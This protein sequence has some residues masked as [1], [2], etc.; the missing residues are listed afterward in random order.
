MSSS[1]NLNSRRHSRRAFLAGGAGIAGAAGAGLLSGCGSGGGP[2]GGGQTYTLI[3]G[4][5]LADGTPFDL[6]LEKF[7]SLVEEKT[8]GQATVEVHPNA[9]LGTELEMFQSI[10][11]GTQDVAIVAPGSIAEF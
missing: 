11:S 9:N 10:Q 3:A 7:A 5:Q 1:A 8:D 2:G 6:G 4:H